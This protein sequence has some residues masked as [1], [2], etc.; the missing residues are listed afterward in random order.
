MDHQHVDLNRIR[1]IH[2]MGVGGAGM[3]GLALLFHELGFNVS[4]CDMGRNSYAEKIEK[5]GVKVLYGHDVGHLDDC[6]VDLLAYSSAIPAANAELC[7]ARERGIPVLQRAELLSLLFDS[8]R[9]IGVA[10]THGKTTTTSMI[11]YILEQADFHPTIAVGGELCDIGCNA[12]I[13][14]GEYMVAELDE[15]DGSFEFFHP[16]YSVVTNVDWDHVNHYP[17]LQSVI[18]AFV[19]FLHN[20]K[21]GGKMFVCGDDPGVKRVLAELPAEMRERVMLFGHDP[22]F[23]Y[24]AENVEFHCGGGLRYTFWAKGKEMGT[25]ELVVSGEHNVVDSLAACGVACELGVPFATVQK[26]LRM[27][28]GAKRRLQL[29]A[30]CPD[31]ILVYD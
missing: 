4:G 26:A 30:M 9:G 17:D 31:N 3:S 19:R 27:F 15:S 14:T 16:F 20:T 5:A 22:S 12:K 10:G 13:G 2:L 21:D 23:D 11:S 24:R 18:D 29:R 28:H 1:N 25:V 8:R 7:R 6:G